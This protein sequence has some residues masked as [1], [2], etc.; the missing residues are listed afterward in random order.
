M[1]RK[2]NKGLRCSLFQLIA[3]KLVRAEIEKYNAKVRD[4]ANSMY[5]KKYKKVKTKIDAL[6]RN[7]F[8]STTRINLEGGSLTKFFIDS[9]SAFFMPEYASKGRHSWYGVEGSVPLGKSVIVNNDD[10]YSVGID[11]KKFNIGDTKKYKA[12]KKEGISLTTKTETLLSELRGTLNG[13]TTVAGLRKILPEF[14]SLYP[15]DEQDALPVCVPQADHLKAAAQEWAGN[16]S[17]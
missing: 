11:V 13:C 16:Q 3:M 14:Q 10:S 6:P 7:F 4:F 15:A 1:K 17:N 5:V 12:L 9:I 2:L 8:R